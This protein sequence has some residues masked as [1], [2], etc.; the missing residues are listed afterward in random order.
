VEVEIAPN[1]KIRIWG[2]IVMLGS[3]KDLG[4]TVEVLQF[5]DGNLFLKHGCG[6][7]DAELDIEERHRLLLLIHLFR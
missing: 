7:A 1:G 2:D 6:R 4:A 3:Y 5:V